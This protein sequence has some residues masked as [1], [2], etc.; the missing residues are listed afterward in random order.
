MIE[1]YDEAAVDEISMRAALYKPSDFFGMEPFLG[2]LM[3]ALAFIMLLILQ[4]QLSFLIAVVI[5][6]VGIPWLRSRGKQDL[7]WTSAIL[8]A[9][10]A[11]KFYPATSYINVQSKTFRKQQRIKRS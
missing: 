10:V 1:D 9:V 8:R 6:V 4:R 5:F 3:V 11:Q 2:L 7:Q